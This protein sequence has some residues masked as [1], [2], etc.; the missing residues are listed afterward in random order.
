VGCQTVGAREEPLQGVVELEERHLSFELPGRVASLK[1]QRG[2][3]VQAGAVL[4]SLDDALERRQRDARAAEARAAQ[5]QRDLVVAGS[6]PEEV[7]SASAEMRAAEALVARLEG[8]AKRS[9]KLAASG[10]EGTARVEEIDAELARAR[11]QVV[12]IRER[13]RLLRGGARKEEID[14][15]GARADAAAAALAAEDERLARHLL[16]TPSAGRVLDVHVEEGEVVGAGAPVVTLAEPR[17]PYV[18]V[19][20]PEARLPAVRLGAS[21]RVRVD[22]DAAPLTGRV[23]HIASQTEFTPRFLFSPRE[24]PNLVMR[25]RVRLE[26]PG[27]RLHAGV[28]AFV[29]IEGVPR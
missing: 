11:E 3:R 23:E 19:F 17:R 5:A 9:H 18:D 12:S 8:E 2:D 24:R 7:R 28:P 15:A 6:R 25:V 20:V 21:A 10:V 26:D 13:V 16:R 4:A 22:G 1:V 27:E 14:L 29:T